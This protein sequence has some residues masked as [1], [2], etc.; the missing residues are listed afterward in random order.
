MQGRGL[1][2]FQEAKNDDSNELAKHKLVYPAL[3]IRS[4]VP[5]RMPII[6]VYMRCKQIDGK[7]HFYIAECE[8]IEAQQ[9]T[10]SISAL[11][12]RTKQHFVLFGFGT[13]L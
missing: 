1:T 13:N 6:P 3:A 10:Y 11:R 2:P 7:K 12:T 8:P 5:P 4:H 9:H